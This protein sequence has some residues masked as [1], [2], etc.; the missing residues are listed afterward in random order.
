MR[1]IIVA[2][3]APL[4]DM[5]ATVCI[6]LMLNGFA[7]IMATV[8]LLPGVPVVEGLANVYA[9]IAVMASALSVGYAVLLAVLALIYRV[10]LGP[11]FLWPNRR[12]ELL[13]EVE[14]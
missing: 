3:M 4:G 12:A 7:W 11:V 8:Y 14:A 1:R 2:F 13:Q 10:P 6:P 5:L 9:I